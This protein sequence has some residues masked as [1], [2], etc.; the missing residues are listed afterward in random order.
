MQAVGDKMQ[1][2]II[3]PGGLKSDPPTG[4]GALTEDKKICGSITR[5]DVADLVVKALRSDKSNGKILS[6]VD[7]N[8]V[9]GGATFDTF[10]L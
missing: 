6:A 7:K 5:G 2:V 9:F 4:N 8:E 10:E 1:W 3:R